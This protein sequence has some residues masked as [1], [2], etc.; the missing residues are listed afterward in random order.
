MQKQKDQELKLMLKYLYEG[1]TLKATKGHRLSA[2]Y[3]F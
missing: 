2:M 1:A 3:L